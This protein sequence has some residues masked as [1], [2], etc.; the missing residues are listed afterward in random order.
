MDTSQIV[1]NVVVSKWCSIKADEDATESKRCKIELTINDVTVLDMANA[2]LKN[3]V[4]RWQG[5]NRKKYDK[6]IDK[7]THRVTFKR[8]IMDV[9]P[10]DAMVARLQAMS[11][12]AERTAYINE[13]LMKAKK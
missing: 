10:E 11:T 9:D 8:P 12:D 5:A 13:V 6:L 1:Q 3:E 2:I 7:A 4:I